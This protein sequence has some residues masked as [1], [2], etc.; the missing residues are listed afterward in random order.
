MAKFLVTYVH[1]GYNSE[2]NLNQTQNHTFQEKFA[3]CGV[4]FQN[5]VFLSILYLF[6]LFCAAS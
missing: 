1:G 2:N 3:N 4:T 6:Q 5:I